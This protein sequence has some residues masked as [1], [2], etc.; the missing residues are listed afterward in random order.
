MNSGD[1]KK[2]AGAIPPIA[3]IVAGAVVVAA[4]VA[5][6]LADKAGAA[7]AGFVNPEPEIGVAVA[8]A[9]VVSAEEDARFSA[10][11][12]ADREAGVTDSAAVQFQFVSATPKSIDGPYTPFDPWMLTVDLRNSATT[13]KTV[14]VTAEARNSSNDPADT[15][16]GEVVGVQ[17]GGLTTREVRFKMNGDPGFAARF[18]SW[19]VQTFVD[20]K[21]SSLVG[22]S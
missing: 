16:R 12:D 13:P 21:R 22:L 11:A 9:P 6:M 17:I 2:I 4:W 15:L 19:D 18:R 10:K 1:A 5:K 3:W 7:I 14:T 20:G 8:K